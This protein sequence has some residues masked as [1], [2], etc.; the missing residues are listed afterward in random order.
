ME[1]TLV[2]LYLCILIYT[3]IRVLLDTYS[4]P[5]TLAYLMLIML[6]PLLGI[7][8]YYA[9]GINFRH[10]R[11]TS[12][13]VHSQT[14]FDFS[15]KNKDVDNTKNLIESNFDKILHFEPLVHFLKGLFQ[16]N[17]SE[18]NFKLLINGEE[19]FPEVLKTLETAEYFIHMEYYDW[20]NDI[21]GNKIKDILLKKSASGLKVRVL[22]DDYASKGIKRNI[23]KELKNGGVE[24][25]P[26]IKVKLAKFANRMNH[27]DHRKIIII[28]G[29]IGFVGGINISDRYDNS[30]DTGLYWRDTHVKFT[31]LLAHNLHRHFIVSWNTAQSE[32]LAYSKALFP[33]VELTI[34][35]DIRALGQVVAGGPIYPM[36]NIM[37]S[38]FRIFSLAKEKLYI[39]NP[40]FIP[41]ES[42][43]D[44]LKQ[45]AVSGVDV[46]LMVPEKSDSA[47]VGA[48]SK[49]YFND[50]LNAG[51]KI[52]LYKK[53]FIHAKTVVADSLVSVVGTANMDIRSFDLNFEIMSV[54]Y[55]KLFA[56]NL[57]KSYLEDIENCSE[58]KIETWNK[59]TI[60]H[61]L[62]Q[63]IARLISSFL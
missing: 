15:Y 48:A 51:V 20:E 34:N 7:V 44:A 45:A 37:L 10:K 63:A 61:R 46:R 16:E 2:T 3:I 56:L 9:F 62:W 25:Y 35:D 50:L 8:V 54:I 41:N 40:Y 5:K 33:T 23:V 4:T 18:N 1:I 17:L 52:Y 24:V 29:K 22:Y 43:M 6:I 26:K 30:I 55:G 39:T 21:I 11:T 13:G 47:I 14:A 12:I 49:F 32:K 57:E 58:I 60:L 19:K 31:G 28:D 38:Y 27:R 59:V 36:S 42:I 53:G